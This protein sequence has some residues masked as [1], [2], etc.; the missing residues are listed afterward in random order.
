MNFRQAEEKDIVPIVH[1][2]N[3]C[4]PYVLAHHDYL[5]WILS[6]YFQSSCF[7][8][9]D[10]GKIIGFISGLPSVD[11]NAVFIWQICVS[12]EYRRKGI[13]CALLYRLYEVSEQNGFDHIQLSIT[14]E[15][16]ASFDMFSRFANKNKLKMELVK[17]VGILKNTENIYKISKL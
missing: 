5:Y 2:L 15:N 11:Q 8:C 10:S 13:A 3:D 9:E 1:L 7:V 12:A 16:S 14:A 6:N 4:R 17:Q